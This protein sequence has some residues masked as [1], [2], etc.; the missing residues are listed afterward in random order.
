MIFSRRG[1]KESGF[2]LACGHKPKSAPLHMF[3]T[4]K[5]LHPTLFLS[6][7]TGPTATVHH[8]LATPS[9]GGRCLVAFPFRGKITLKSPNCWRSRGEETC[10]GPKTFFF[11]ESWCPTNPLRC[12]QVLGR[13]PHGKAVLSMS[14]AP[15]PPRFPL[16]KHDDHSRFFKAHAIAL[17]SLISTS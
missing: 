3:L 7:P 4:T 1:D 2:K 16:T 8:G 14:S 15:A 5:R 12:S 9:T 13:M 10:H 17:H 11:V 6:K